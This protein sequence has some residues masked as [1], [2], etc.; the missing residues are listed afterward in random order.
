MKNIN[1]FQEEAKARAAYSMYFPMESI[2]QRRL[3][4]IA[5][6]LEIPIEIVRASNDDLMIAIGRFLIKKTEVIYGS[7]NLYV[8]V[9][10]FPHIDPNNLLETITTRQSVPEN[11]FEFLRSFSIKSID[12]KLNRTKISFR[13]L[14]NLQ[15]H[16]SQDAQVVIGYLC[17]ISASPTAQIINELN[18]LESAIQVM[19]HAWHRRIAWFNDDSNEKIKAANYYAGKKIPGVKEIERNP[20][21]R[22]DSKIYSIPIINQKDDVEIFFYNPY[23]PNEHKDVVYAKI[24]DLY[25]TRKSRIKSKQKNCSFILDSEAKSLIEEMA[26][27]HKI[28]GSNLL[29][30]IFQKSNRA[31]LKRLLEKMPIFV[32]R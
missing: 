27:E 2:S 17:D 25:N 7:F 24:R 9:P 14:P 6:H 10:L 12:S 26:K 20:L 28:K 1:Q 8:R 31:D 30:F 19:D 15:F 11:S 18:N 16:R 29:N 23:I 22:N 5:F 3:R 13:H 32:Q 4:S 21:L